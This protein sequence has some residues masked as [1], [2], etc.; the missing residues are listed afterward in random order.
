MFRLLPELARAPGG[1]DGPALREAGSKLAVQLLT[2][3]W[4]A[5]AGAGRDLF[6]TLQARLILHEALEGL[7]P[8]M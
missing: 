1:E 4:E 2:E 8:S 7:R 5:C 3:H 6:R